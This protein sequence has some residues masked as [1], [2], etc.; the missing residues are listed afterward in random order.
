MRNTY[1]CKNIDIAY[2]GYFFKILAKYVW[3]TGGDKTKIIKAHYGDLAGTV[4]ASC[5]AKQYY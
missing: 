2:F 4:G 3:R 5:F 1:L